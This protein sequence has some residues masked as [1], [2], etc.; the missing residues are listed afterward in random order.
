MDDVFRTVGACCHTT[1]Q[2]FHTYTTHHRYNKHVKNLV[3]DKSHP[4][5]HLSHSAA[6]DIA[7]RFLTL[8]ESGMYDIKADPCHICVLSVPKAYYVPSLREVADLRMLGVGVDSLSVTAFA[9]AHIMGVHFRAGEWDHH[10]RCGSVVTCVINGRSLYARVH[11]FL[12]VDDDDSPGY[13]SV[14]WFDSPL[15][16]FDVPLVVRVK[17]DGSALDA[18]I[19][20][21]IPITSIDPSQVVIEPLTDNDS[22]YMMRES[23]YDTVPVQ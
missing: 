21:I 19:G 9:V 12:Q 3:R 15:Y 22:S 23:G 2:C 20:T 13:A 1:H 18:K 4:E 6:N 17:Y 7:T 10:P 8:A 5:V 11:R 14:S 16:P